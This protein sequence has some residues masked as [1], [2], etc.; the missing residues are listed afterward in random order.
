MVFLH[1]TVA[2]KNSKIG[3]LYQNTNLQLTR[4]RSCDN[5]V[6]M[7]KKIEVERRSSMATNIKKNSSSASC[8]NVFVDTSYSSISN[9]QF[10]IY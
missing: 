2:K 6:K 9:Y 10:F 7:D 4:Y 3:A 1:L 5:L 8:D